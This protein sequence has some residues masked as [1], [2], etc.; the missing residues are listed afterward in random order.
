MMDG[1]VDLL[2]LIRDKILKSCCEKRA[3]AELEAL[4]GQD[5]TSF[6]PP[7]EREEGGS[8]GMSLG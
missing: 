5:V 7:L 6:H 8:S 4:A 1:W 3:L 2:I